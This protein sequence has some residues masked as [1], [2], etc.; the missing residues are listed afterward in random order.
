MPNSQQQSQPA[1]FFLSTAAVLW[2]GHDFFVFSAS[3]H[4]SQTTHMN[5]PSLNRRG[6]AGRRGKGIKQE[7]DTFLAS[8]RVLHT[9]CSWLFPSDAHVDLYTGGFFLVLFRRVPE[10]SYNFHVLRHASRLRLNAVQ[11]AYARGISY[12]Y[13]FLTLVSFVGAQIGRIRRWYIV[14]EDLPSLLR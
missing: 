3:L 10:A 13:E 12:D 11:P 8:L 4:Q 6:W 9:G 7:L 2:G 1:D 14:I 5:C